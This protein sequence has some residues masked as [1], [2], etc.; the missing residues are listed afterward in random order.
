MMSR[1]PM[2]FQPTQP[3]EHHR[4]RLPH[5]P[6][7]RYQQPILMYPLGFDAS[8]FYYRDRHGMFAF[9]KKNEI[10]LII[11]FVIIQE[12]NNPFRKISIQ[13]FLMIC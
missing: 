13:M 2:P 11:V 7:H 12:Q 1:Y 3:Y 6:R 9:R 5:R 8:R 4:R 10:L